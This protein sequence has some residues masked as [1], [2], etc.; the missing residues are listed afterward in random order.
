MSTFNHNAVNAYTGG[1][2][3]AGKAVSG[4]L[5]LGT[6]GAATSLTMTALPD[7][8]DTVQ[9]WDG[10]L[11]IA[12]FTFLRQRDVAK[13]NVAQTIGKA[14]GDPRGLIVHVL[15]DGGVTGAYSLVYS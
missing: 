12:Q 7:I 11:C 6:T 8:G 2:G 3:A 15:S 10:P 9:I 1:H 14:Y 5:A 4:P 13:L